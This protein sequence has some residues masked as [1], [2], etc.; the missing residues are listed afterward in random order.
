MA[1]IL[2]VDDDNLVRTTLANFLAH[3]G[4]Q[5]TEAANGLEA[6]RLL[7]AE[8]FDLVLTDIIMPEHDGLELLMSQ[9]MQPDRPK[10]IAISGGSPNLSQHELLDIALKMKADAVL[11]KPVS[12]ETLSATV[13]SALAGT[14]Q[15]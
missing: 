15:Q 11:A 2:L 6:K 9:F 10:I 12:Y 14:D 4:H 8:T 3:D 1:R 13:R 5:V 7:T